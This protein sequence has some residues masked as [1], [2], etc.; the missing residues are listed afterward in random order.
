MDDNVTNEQAPPTP[1]SSAMASPALEGF[2]ESLDGRRLSPNT[3][4]SYLKFA[5]HYLAWLGTVAADHPEALLSEP[6][7]DRAVAAYRADRLDL[8]S[9]TTNVSVAALTHFYEYLGIGRPIDQRVDHDAAPARSLSA[10]EQRALLA[11]AAAEADRNAEVGT[12]ALAML[13]LGLDAGPREL[14]LLALD[15]TDLNCV[16]AQIVVTDTRGRRRLVPVHRQTIV[17]IQP[18]LAIRPRVLGTR[19]QDATALFVTLRPSSLRRTEPEARRLSARSVDQIVRT[20]GIGAGL[21]ISP[22]VLRATARDRMWQAG[23]DP[24]EIAA[25]LGQQTLRRV[26]TSPVA[27]AP[28]RSVRQPLTVAEQLDLFGDRGNS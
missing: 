26:P 16:G 17:L 15:E 25:R 10:P 4:S 13:A 3:R 6:G 28:G 19:D 24:A 9:G 5:S 18:W 8:A 21:D 22:N 11:A 12:R 27:T 1:L 23:V 14:E 20:A 2:A 7:R